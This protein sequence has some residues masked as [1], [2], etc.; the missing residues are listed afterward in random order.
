MT[1]KRVFSKGIRI[2]FSILTRLYNGIH[3]GTEANLI[4]LVFLKKHRKHQMP[5]KGEV[6][7]KKITSD[8][9]TSISAMFRTHPPT[10][11]KN[12]VSL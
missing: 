2:Q 9:F 3:A 5:N 6:W 11:V 10:H 1:P 12:P 8:A 4:S 7:K